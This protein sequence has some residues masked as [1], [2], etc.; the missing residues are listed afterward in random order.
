MTN[1]AFI[2]SFS[3]APQTAH[4]TNPAPLLKTHQIFLAAA[5]ACAA[6]AFTPLHAED[7]GEP[8]QPQTPAWWTAP[9]TRIINADAPQN[10]Y[11]PLNVGQL[12]H[13]ATQAHAYFESL[14]SGGAGFPLTDLFPAPPGPA[15]PA[16]PQWRTANYAP[17]NIGQLKAVGLPFYNQ[18]ISFGIDTRL[19]LWSMGYPLNWNSPYPWPEPPPQGEPGTPE[20]ATYEAWLKGNYVPANIGQ[21]KMVFSFDLGQSTMFEGIPDSW[22][23]E[24]F[25]TLEGFDPDTDAD[26]DGL[27]NRQEFQFGTDPNN[28][29]TDGDGLPDGWEVDNGL[30]PLDDGS[31]DPN[32]GP[33]GGA[34]VG[35]GST[36][37]QLY[38]AGKN[39]D[40]EVLP[41]PKA[42]TQFYPTEVSVPKNL[43]AFVWTPGS[44][45]PGGASVTKQLLYRNDE[46]LEELGMNVSSYQ[47]TSFALPADNGITLTYRI[48][49]E[50]AAGLISDSAQLQVRIGDFTR[51]LVWTMAKTWEASSSGGFGE[52]VTSIEDAETYQYYNVIDYEYHRY[53]RHDYDIPK[54]SS[55]ATD[56]QDAHAVYMP[57]SGRRNWYRYTTAG[58]SSSG[59]EEW[60]FGSGPNIVGSNWTSWGPTH[61]YRYDSPPI[62]HAGE[63]WN[64][65]RYRLSQ[66]ITAQMRLGWIS[67]SLGSGRDPN[68]GQIRYDRPPEETHCSDIVSSI[69][70]DRIS[71]AHYS[72]QNMAV[73]SRAAYKYKMAPYSRRDTRYRYY[74]LK[75]RLFIPYDKRGRPDESQ[76]QVL[77]TEKIILSESFLAACEETIDDYDDPDT[78]PSEVEWVN[79][80][81]GS[82]GEY[83]VSLSGVSHEISTPETMQVPPPPQGQT[84]SDNIIELDS[85][86]VT[87]MRV[88]PFSDSGDYPYHWHIEFATIEIAGE[89]GLI[90]F[91]PTCS[92]AISKGQVTLNGQIMQALTP[93]GDGGGTI[94]LSGQDLHTFLPSPDQWEPRVGQIGL[95]ATKPGTMTVTLRVKWGNSQSAAQSPQLLRSSPLVAVDT[96]KIDLLPY[97]D[98]G[99]DFDGDG[100][101]EYMSTYDKATHTFV[102]DGDTKTPRRAH[103]L[104]A[105]DPDAFYIWNND[106]YD[107]EAREK[108]IDNPDG[109]GA[110]NGADD[111][112]NGRRD[113]EDL[114][115]IR[116][117]IPGA[118]KIR[119]F[120]ESGKMELYIESN[121][122]SVANKRRKW[123][124]YP[125]VST[126]GV[127][128]DLGISPFAQVWLKAEEQMQQKT[129]F[130]SEGDGARRKAVPYSMLRF[131]DTNEDAECSFLLETSQTLTL[132][133]SAYVKSKSDAFP[134]NPGSQLTVHS[135]PVKTMMEAYKCEQSGAFVTNASVGNR[136]YLSGY[137]QYASAP[138]AEDEKD[139][140]LLVHGYNMNEQ[141]KKNIGETMF[142]R[143][144]Q[145]GYKGRAGVFLWPCNTKYYFDQSEF[146]AWKS[147]ETLLSL[148]MELKDKGYRVHLMGHSQGNTIACEALKLYFERYP[149][150]ELL[151]SYS[152][153]QAAITASVFTTYWRLQTVRDSPTSPDV[154]GHYPDGGAESVP[155]MHSLDGDSGSA[156]ITLAAKRWINFYNPL[157][158]ALSKW[159]FNQWCKPDSSKFGTMGGFLYEVKWPQ[160]P[161]PGAEYFRNH[162]TQNPASLVFDRDRYEIFSF[163]AGAYLRALGAV[164]LDRTTHFIDRPLGA[165]FTDHELDHSGQFNYWMGK[166]VNFWTTFMEDS[167]IKK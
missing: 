111:R 161:E 90:A 33:N 156:D 89:G 46:L 135:V 165:G 132:R 152:A 100:E 50:D 157:D 79:H 47:D 54:P 61:L 86:Y 154:Y 107:T 83:A 114:H 98:I 3:S 49:T 67:Q 48:M 41:R 121:V 25:G 22:I 64:T 55:V 31:G 167:G 14:L 137:A 77:D 27:T 160:K 99:A 153:C 39:R 95:Y 7:V 9:A 133:L 52:F 80:V 8:A 78:Y 109:K 32:N 125:S 112:I 103:L 43:V 58:G 149:S 6:A 15:D 145:L 44:A 35:Y 142:K 118:K 97:I 56:D 131:S 72:S 20:R 19:Y 104:A 101:I 102:V 60:N 37:K 82:Q 81:I 158:Y 146:I 163:V 136:R 26:G 45:E 1:S 139:Y 10:N 143:L 141:E 155:Y 164:D 76:M 110:P 117:K 40:E 42:P 122:A 36:N 65:T 94:T 106:D 71:A 162:Q 147:A 11:G 84:N 134:K 128:D 151:E 4:T 23:I 123:N 116:F 113:L 62:S 53:F 129:F 96:K 34:G 150:V 57:K 28:P 120:L 38:D 74:V 105:V 51:M 18:L 85:E 140:V 108:E 130:S 126:V 115:L 93:P 59:S 24:H 144:F 148:L 119:P 21:L 5:F 87:Y 127:R 17:A 91:A 159:N 166:H 16:Y 138:A 13:T 92:S 70:A 75:H 69:R 73:V 68:F 30:D 124:M 63:S 12:K 66:P 88:D 29:D 2:G